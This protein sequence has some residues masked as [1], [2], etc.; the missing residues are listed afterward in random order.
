MRRLARRLGAYTRRGMIAAAMGAVIAAFP[1]GAALAHAELALAKP[2]PGTGLAQ[3]PAAVV[4]KFTEPLNIS[5]S[6]IEVLDATGSDVGTGTTQAVAGDPTAMQRRLGLL[7]VG[8]YTVTWTTVS[9]LD[10]HSLHGSYRFGVGTSAAPDEQVRSSPVESEGVLGLVGRFIALLG[11][12][13]WLG[14]AILGTRAARGGLPTSTVLRVGRIAPALALAGMAV[15]VV[16]SSLVATGSITGLPGVFASGSGQVRAVVLIASFAG[17]I[18][19]VRLRIVGLAL[20]AVA[21]LGEA[22]SG[23]AATSP[24]PVLATA[25]WAAHLGAVGVWLFAVLAALLSWPRLR[26]MLAAMSTPAIVAAG[27]VALSGVASAAFVLSDAGQLFSTDYGLFLVAK[28]FAFA[29]M[30]SFGLIHYVL[31]RNPAQSA[32]TIRFPVRYEAMAGLFA[33]GLAAILVGF[34]NPPREGEAGAQLALVDPV[35]EQLGNRDALSL[36]GA[37]GPFV[38]GLTILPPEPGPVE[39]RLQIV[40]LEAGDAPRDARITATG[41]DT[42]Q[43]SLEAC[44]LGCFAGHASLAPGLWSIEASVTT[45]RDL[46]TIRVELP[47]PTPDGRTEFARAILAMEGLPSAR[48]NEQLQGFVGGDTYLTQYE[49]QAPDRMRITSASAERIVIG[50]RDFRRQADGSWLVSPWGGSPFIWPG[51]YYGDFWM[52]AAAIRMVGNEIVD[53]IPSNVVA[54]VRPE[55]PAWFRIWVGV[56]D[57]LVRRMEMRAEGHLMEQEWA[58]NAPVSIEPPP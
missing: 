25:V 34:P 55:I 32:W 1:A 41:P 57:G 8:Q 29:L 6:R 16:S 15:A 30:A 44:G 21:I 22:A 54:F 9:S 11:L 35:L 37:S 43:T 7:P 3:A 28:A 19:G 24:A 33:I 48:L 53:G 56:N 50:D 12:G 52:N 5:I 58:P 27:A 2:V 39:Y 31:R 38:V 20:A 23:H 40:G 14:V 46:A 13:V 26:E 36:A 4:L 47:L 10:G 51:S 45:N 18:V 17:L 49:L 42:V